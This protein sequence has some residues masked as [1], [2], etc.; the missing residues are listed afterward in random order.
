MDATPA[1]A[2]TVREGCTLEMIGTPT[3]PEITIPIVVSAAQRAQ[4]AVPNP[5]GAVTIMLDEAEMKFAY[6]SIGR[7]LAGKFSPPGSGE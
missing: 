7:V 2:I 6:S 4:G 1:L 3:E 5:D